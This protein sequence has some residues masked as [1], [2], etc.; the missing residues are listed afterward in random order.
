M[1]KST[2]RE[3]RTDTSYINQDGKIYKKVVTYSL[4]GNASWVEGDGNDPT[5]SEARSILGL[6]KEKPSGEV[7]PTRT[8]TVESNK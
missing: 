1:P 2:E 8:S 6:D 7:I 3:I 4:V 5:I